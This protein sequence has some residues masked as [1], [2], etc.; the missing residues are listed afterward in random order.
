[1]DTGVHLVTKENMD[2]P[3]IKELVQPDLKKWL[4]E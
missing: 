3:D 2:Q 1:V 4:K